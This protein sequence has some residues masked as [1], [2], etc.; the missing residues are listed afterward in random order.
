MRTADPTFQGLIEEE[1]IRLLMDD[2]EPKYINQLRRD[3]RSWL[4]ADAKY[5]AR[6]EHWPESAS[7]RKA[8]NVLAYVTHPDY[9]PMALSEIAVRHFGSDHALDRGGRDSAGRVARAVLLRFFQHRRC[10]RRRTDAE[11]CV[12]RALTGLTERRILQAERIADGDIASTVS[13]IG[14]DN[15]DPLVRAARRVGAPCTLTLNDLMRIPPDS[16]GVR[17]NRVFALENPN[18]FFAVHRATVRALGSEFEPTIVCLM[19]SF[20]HACEV[21]LEALS[22]R[23]DITYSVDSDTGGRKIETR[24]LEAFPNRVTR[25]NAGGRFEEE[26]VADFLDHLAHHLVGRL[27]REQLEALG[28]EVALV[29]SSRDDLEG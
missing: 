2:S 15:N 29:R 5:L 12:P 21:L 11:R 4:G 25:W 27:P 14:L 28:E 8:L 23:A 19:G 18:V 1:V 7:F 3:L 22:V 10:I 6:Y 20:S 13:F 24:L 17:Y 26:S 9:E 16:W